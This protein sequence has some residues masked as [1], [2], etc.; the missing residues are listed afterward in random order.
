[1]ASWI[2]PPKQGR[3]IQLQEGEE[4]KTLDSHFLRSLGAFSSSPAQ[5][6]LDLQL[7]SVSISLLPCSRKHLLMASFS[8]DLVYLPGRQA[9]PLCEVLPA[10]STPAHGEAPLML[11]SVCTVCLSPAPSSFLSH[12][13][14]V[15]G[16]ASLTPSYSSFQERKAGQ[17]QLSGSIGGL[18]WSRWPRPQEAVG[19][20]KGP[21]AWASQSQDSW[22]GSVV[23]HRW[24]YLPALDPWMGVNQGGRW[25]TEQAQGSCLASRLCAGRPSGSQPPF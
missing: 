4:E 14:L 25:R 15:R 8:C 24:S 13:C 3:S 6:S 17:P 2:A 9:G 22:E 11:M 5:R 10:G 23:R 1:M 21:W 7:Y 19:A 18:V 16:R 12:C 20:G